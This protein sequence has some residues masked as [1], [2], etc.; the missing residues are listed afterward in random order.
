VGVVFAGNSN[1]VKYGSR[2]SNQVPAV[3]GIRQSALRPPAV[4]NRLTGSLVLKCHL[5]YNEI[6]NDEAA[7]YGTPSFNVNNHHAASFTTDKLDGVHLPART[8]QA[9]MPCDRQ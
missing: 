5:I 9:A 7:L 1:S 8:V 3:T 2:I 6:R 4:D